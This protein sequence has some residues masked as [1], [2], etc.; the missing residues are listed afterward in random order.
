MGVK[1]EFYFVRPEITEPFLVGL[2]LIKGEI[3]CSYSV[4][5]EEIQLFTD[6]LRCKP[7]FIQSEAGL[8]SS[9]AVIYLTNL[10]LSGFGSTTAY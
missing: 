3:G 4:Q 10:F 7:L 9:N 2:T 5:L 6:Y 8:F 1:T